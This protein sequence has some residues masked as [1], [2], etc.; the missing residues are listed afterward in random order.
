MLLV[1]FD[2]VQVATYGLV[3]SPLVVLGWLFRRMAL[4]TR[5][6]ARQQTRRARL[7]NDIPAEMRWRVFERDEYICQRC[8]TQND[9]LVDFRDEVPSERA[10][11]LHQLI[12]RCVRCA[13][14]TRHSG[15]IKQ[16]TRRD[17]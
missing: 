2:P 7:L 13:A 11:R 16:A 12:T 5:Q 1:L 4:R 14:I 9:L 3:L 8:G 6:Q 15:M 10:V 17:D